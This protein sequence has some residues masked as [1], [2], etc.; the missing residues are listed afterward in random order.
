[1]CD[2]TRRKTAD[3][4]KCQRYL[5]F[6][7]ERGM[8]TGE[9]Q[10]QAVVRHCAEAAAVHA[11]P[12]SLQQQRKLG[13]QGALPAEDVERRTGSEPGDVLPGHG[14]VRHELVARIVQAYDGDAARKRE[15]G[16]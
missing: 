15:G 10:S 5:G 12:L 6:W 3:Q 14:V 7:R 8:T 1:M 2:I 4:P 16:K 11:L 13:L 9:D